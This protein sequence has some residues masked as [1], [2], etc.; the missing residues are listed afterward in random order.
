M[1]KCLRTKDEPRITNS[2]HIILYIHVTLRQCNNLPIV[3]INL[4]F[5]LQTSTCDR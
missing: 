4:A 2:K 1:K 3:Y 5:I